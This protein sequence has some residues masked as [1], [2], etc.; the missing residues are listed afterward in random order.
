M[1]RY[2]TG[3]CLAAAIA[4]LL[5]TAGCKQKRLSEAVFPLEWVGNIE[6]QGFN[7]PSGLCYHKARGTLFVVGD[8]GDV[9]EM[10]TDGS[11]LHE[12][13]IGSHDL[14]GITHDPATGLLYAAVEGEDKVLELH[15]DSLGVRREFQLP[16]EFEG[17][18]IM[19]SGGNGI[20]A[21][22]FAPDPEHPQGGTFYVT[23][24]VFALDVADDRSAIIHTELPLRSG[25]VVTILDVFE[26]GII[27]LSGLHYDAATGHLFMIGDVA[28]AI[29]EYGPGYELI[30]AWAFPGDNQEGITFDDDGYLYIAQDSGGILKY[31]RLPAER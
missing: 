20:E 23:N 14:E 18:T 25:E 16:R 5:S 22:T 15:P 28:N 4:L 9:C 26:P 29:A 19:K 24:Q 8:N 10:Q 12:R 27:D 7:E 2:V 21:I 11:M 17:H 13:H 6:R 3:L 30:G 31:R 1:K